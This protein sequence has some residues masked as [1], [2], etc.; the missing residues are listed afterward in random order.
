MS[1]TYWLY[2]WLWGSLDWVFPPVCGGC[3]RA[4]FRWCPDCRQ[5][6]QI[7]PEPVCRTC[8]LPLSGPGQCPS[9]KESVP[10][11]EMMRSWLVFEGPIRHALHK[12][13]Y[14]RNVALGDALAQPFAE[15]VGTLGWTVDLVIPVPLGKER[16]KERGYNQ[17]GL[18]AMPLA[19]V[20]HWR[21]AP[22][23]LARSRETRSQVGLTVAERKENVSGAFRA[24]AALVSGATVLLLD[25][26]ATTGATLSACTTALLYAGVRTVYALTLARA[27]PHHGLNNV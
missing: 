6:V 15:Y 22:R 4:G 20:N 10:P 23:A 3:D 8:G 17:V 26:V 19:A 16:M 2:Q 21:Y 12:L 25:D 18:V 9:C 5:Q 11:Y 1:S 7:V 24:D 14:R 27:L 13:K